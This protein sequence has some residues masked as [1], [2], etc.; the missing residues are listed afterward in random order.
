MSSQNSILIDGFTLHV[1]CLF[2]ITP[3]EYYSLNEFTK[4][5]FNTLV[6]A[7]VLHDQIKVGSDVINPKRRFPELF[8]LFN[9]CLLEVETVFSNADTKSKE[10]IIRSYN[11]NKERFDDLQRDESYEDELTSYVQKHFFES[12]T[13]PTR[14][15]LRSSDPDLFNI[16]LE[17]Q[18]LRARM[19]NMEADANNLVYLPSPY[20]VELSELKEI[21]STFAWDLINNLDTEVR[22]QII[23]SFKEDPIY[24][25][26]P[27]DVATPPL[28]KYIM[29]QGGNQSIMKSALEIR[30]SKEAKDFR[31]LCNELF[32]AKELRIRTKVKDEISE[33]KQIWKKS[34]DQS[35]L[36][37]SHEISLKFYG[38]AGKMPISW[39]RRFKRKA[40]ILMYKISN[41]I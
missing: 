29:N 15:S 25:R 36:R 5:S 37:Q 27:F 41:A 31:K 34:L 4:K 33:L 11:I 13:N 8:A 7:L 10:D 1:A 32:S 16:F 12:S 18:K 35:N 26:L 14:E 28:L 22:L 3:S 6:Q 39:R 38:L 9:D 17:H 24:K 19:Y 21:Q 30:N 2:N 20:R 23:K 40:Y